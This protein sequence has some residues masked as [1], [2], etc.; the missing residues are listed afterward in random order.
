MS[1]RNSLK[2]S[3]DWGAGCTIALWGSVFVGVA[4]SGLAH[5]TNGLNQIGFGTESMGMAGADLA[6]ARDS[7]ALNTNPAGLGFQAGRRLDL[8]MALGYTG[9]AQHRDALG[10]RAE[11]QNDLALLSSLGYVQG[12]ESRPVTWGVGLFAQGGAGNQFDDL[13]TPFGT[14]DDIGVLFRVARLT[15][16][17]AWR[18]ND[19]LSL[20]GS[21]VLT[22]S[23]MEQEIFPDTSFLGPTP[24]GSFFGQ[25]ITGL[26]SLDSGFKLGLMYRPN[27]RLT[28]GVAYTSQVDIVLEGGT[29]EA[30]MSALGLGKVSYR[31][32]RVSGLNQPRE[33]G[34]GLAYQ[35]TPGLL[36]A[37]EFN[38]ID[39]SA[40]VKQGR[41]RA[42]DPD[43][44]LAPGSLELTSLYQ[45]RDQTVIALGATYQVD[46]ALALR[47]GYNYGRNPIPE[48]HFN[49]LLNGTAEHHLTLGLGWRMGREWWLDGVFEWDLENNLTYTN[50]ELPFGADAEAVGEV[51]A[52]HLRLSRRW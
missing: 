40:A 42:S 51:L 21:L 14:R 7:S 31:Q 50:P 30:D 11:N 25:K 43:N 19:K 17:A 12:L 26:D 5:G 18:V 20:G 24:A 34:L 36:L 44:P 16:G 32:L 1:G 33:L 9:A 22:Y 38:W 8:N 23:D 15:P 49:P 2:R 41:L 39:W 3:D 10:N 29:L 27:E 47:V 37:L 13:T 46:P 28:L 6:V 4:L 45:W 52:L 48:N 35:V